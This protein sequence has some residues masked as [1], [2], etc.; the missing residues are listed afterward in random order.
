MRPRSSARSSRRSAGAG[1]DLPHPRHREGAR[2]HRGG[3]G[4]ILRDIIVMGA[5]PIALLD[6]LHFGPPEDDKSRWVANGVIDGISSYGNCIGVPT[7]GGEVHFDECYRQN[8]LVNV[9]AIGLV[10]P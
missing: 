4:G 1:L 9:M 7:V 10:G 2:A 8:P 3:V 6:S 5:R